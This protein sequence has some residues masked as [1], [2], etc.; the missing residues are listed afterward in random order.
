M[1]VMVLLLPL[2]LLTPR[3][4]AQGGGGSWLLQATP[5]YSKT[6]QAPSYS[7]TP[8]TTPKRMLAHQAPSY[9]NYSARGAGAAGTYYYYYYYYYIIE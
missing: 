6:H 1:V 2:N 3:V 8:S 9:S 7:T 5:N 4:T